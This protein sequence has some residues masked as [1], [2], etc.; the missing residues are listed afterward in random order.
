MIRLQKPPLGV[1]FY[2]SPQEHPLELDKK[3]QMRYNKGTECQSNRH[4]LKVAF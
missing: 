2:S 4:P 1:S 3:A